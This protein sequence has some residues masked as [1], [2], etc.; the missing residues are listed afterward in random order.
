MGRRTRKAGIGPVPPSVH[1][2]VGG[3]YAPPLRTQI[4]YSSFPKADVAG[5]NDSRSNEPIRPHI[6][7]KRGGNALEPSGVDTL[8]ISNREPR[9]RPGAA[10]IRYHRL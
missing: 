6:R 2:M 8:E 4:L 3:W 10:A 9:R 1:F 5:E 7:V